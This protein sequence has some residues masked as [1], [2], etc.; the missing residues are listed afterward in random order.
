MKCYLEGNFAKTTKKN[1]EN[2]QFEIS[3]IAFI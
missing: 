3:K 2:G 1:S